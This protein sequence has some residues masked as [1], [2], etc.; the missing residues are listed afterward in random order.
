MDRWRLRCDVESGGY[1]L[2]NLNDGEESNVAIGPVGRYSARSHAMRHTRVNIF[3]QFESVRF[4]LR[5]TPWT[6][7]VLLPG[8]EQL[9]RL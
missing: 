8:L 2:F 7:Y 9:Q 1:E 3:L 4:V 6:C 5:V